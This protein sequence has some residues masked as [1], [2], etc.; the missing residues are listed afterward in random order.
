MNAS[1]RTQDSAA[2]PDMHQRDAVA[3]WRHINET[4]EGELRRIA[5]TL[6]DEAGQLLVSVHLQLAQLARVQPSSSE[7]VL[8]CQELLGQVERQLRTLS[9]EL[10]P[11]LLDDLGW[12][13]ALEFLAAAVAARSQVPVEVRSALSQRLPPAYEISLYRVVQEALANAARHAHA[14]RICI[15]IGR[16]RDSVVGLIGDDGVGFDVDARLREGG[17]G[18]K[19]MRARLAAVG[20]SLQLVSEPGH[21]S[22]IR[23]RVPMRW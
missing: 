15:E 22:E 14:H 21:G 9:H 17:L 23:F 11:M 10:R 12:L 3:A 16:N 8:A 7:R 1:A 13:P 20:G 5:H 18:L 19:G 2:T 6:H 4:L